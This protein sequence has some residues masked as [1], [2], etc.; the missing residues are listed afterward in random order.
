MTRNT[1]VVLPQPERSLARQIVGIIINAIGIGAGVCGCY[2]AYMTISTVIEMTR[3]PPLRTQP[4][5]AA[6]PGIALIG[7][8][9]L[10][11]IV[12]FGVV[13]AFSL[14]LAVW[15]LEPVRR[16]REWRGGIPNR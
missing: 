10:L 11:A 16:W 3:L 1:P 2:F 9:D 5:R 7:G 14:V 12:V 15:I 4:G 8:F 13:A 6:S